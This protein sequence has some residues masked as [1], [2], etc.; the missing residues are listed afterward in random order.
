MPA[1]RAVCL[2]QPMER[3]PERAD[4]ITAKA[5]M[6]VSPNVNKHC[7]DGR[8]AGRQSFLDILRFVHIFA[9]HLPEGSAF[10][11]AGRTAKPLYV[12]MTDYAG[13]L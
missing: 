11:E 6:T 4:D 3:Q 9:A 13:V 1:A 8:T 12:E 2:R 5:G 10:S 7:H